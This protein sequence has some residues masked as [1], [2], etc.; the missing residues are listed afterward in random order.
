MVSWRG[1]YLGA[2]AGIVWGWLSML[3]NWF[4]GVFPFEAGLVYNIIAF[5]VG[6]AVFGIVAGG[7]V[8]AMEGWLPGGTVLKGIIVS[9]SLWLVLRIGGTVL[10]V[11][12]PERYHLI[13]SQ[14]LQGLVLSIILGFILGILLYTGER[15]VTGN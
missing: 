11:L 10:S 1:V 15:T 2:I 5:A 6:G 7:F 8:V 13:F 4:T 14:S 12:N 3:V 9:T